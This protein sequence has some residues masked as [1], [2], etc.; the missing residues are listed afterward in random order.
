MF[1]L[2]YAMTVLC[3]NLKKREFST[4]Y[5]S[6]RD[7]CLRQFEGWGEQDQIE[8]V[9]HLLARMC[10]YQHGHINTFLKPM[11]QRDFVSLLPSN[12]LHLRLR[13]IYSTVCFSAHRKG[14]GPCC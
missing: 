5:L 9:E 1:C 10:H 3:D 11:L 7:L 13:H 4:H 14:S 8:F 6:Q 12:I 2:Q